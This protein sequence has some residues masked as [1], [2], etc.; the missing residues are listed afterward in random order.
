M[1][2][3]CAL[4]DR[5]NHVKLHLPVAADVADVCSFF[6]FFCIIC[7]GNWGV[8]NEEPQSLLSSTT[9]QLM[10]VCGTVQLGSARHGVLCRNVVCLCGTAAAPFE[11]PELLLFPLCVPLLKIKPK[12]KT[13]KRIPESLTI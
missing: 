10:S 1:L 2:R 12:T 13:P 8:F 4:S 6:F 3:L 11:V 9:L 5:S 7:G